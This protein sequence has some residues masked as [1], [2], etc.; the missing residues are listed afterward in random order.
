MV[1]GQF[2]GIGERFMCKWTSCISGQGIR[3]GQVAKREA[4]S[5]WHKAEG[6]PGQVVS[7]KNCASTDVALV[8]S[9]GPKE[10]EVSKLCLF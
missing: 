10:L 4:D 7:E 6:P 8:E 5:L 9:S 3:C 2:S 1:F